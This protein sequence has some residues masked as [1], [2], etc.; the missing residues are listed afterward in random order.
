MSYTFE[1]SKSLSVPRLRDAIKSGLPVKKLAD[2]QSASGLTP[3]E[4]FSILRLDDRLLAQRKKTR[5][6]TADESERLQRLAGCFG[7]AVSLFDGDADRARDWFR[8]P[9]PALSGLT[10]LDMTDTE[11]GAREVESLIGRLEHGVFA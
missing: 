4:I 8:K 7:Q 1:I 3:S 5:R 2:F 10:P 6:L 11:V 9:I